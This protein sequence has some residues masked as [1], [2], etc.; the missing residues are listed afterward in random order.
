MSKN[1]SV[2]A[3]VHNVIRNGKHGP[4]AVAS[5]EKLGSITFA[6]DSA[7]WHEEDDPEPGEVVFLSKLRKKRAGWKAMEARRLRPSEA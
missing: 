3:V 1:E 7:V 2:Q 4:Y 5:D 6:L